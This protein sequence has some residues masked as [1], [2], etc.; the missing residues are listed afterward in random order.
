MGI[1]HQLRSMS[2]MSEE[3]GENDSLLA[4]NHVWTFHKRECSDMGNLSTSSRHARAVSAALPQDTVAGLCR[5]RSPAVSSVYSRPSS[6]NASDAD[7]EEKPPYDFPNVDG[8]F[9]DWPLKPAVPSGDMAT[10]EEEALLMTAAATE[11]SQPPVTPPEEAEHSSPTASVHTVTKGTPFGQ[12]FPLHRRAT[13]LKSK[14]SSSTLTVSSKRSR[15]LER[16]SPPK[17]TVKKRRSIFKFLRPGSRKQQTRSVSSPALRTN[18]FKTSGSYDG[19]SDDPSLL[20]V[21]YELT[22]TPQHG[23]RSTS[24]SHSSPTRRGTVSHLS[25]P[26]ELQRQPSMANYERRLTAA[27]DSRR[28]S[29]SVSVDKLQEVKEDDHRDSTLLRRKLSRAKPLADEDASLMAQALEKHQQEKALFRS[30][31]KQREVLG[32]QHSQQTPLFRT[33]TLTTTGL[34]L[35]PTSTADHNDLLDPLDQHGAGRSHSISYLVPPEASVTASSQRASTAG[36][37]ETSASRRLS[38]ATVPPDIP[39]PPQPVKKIGTSLASWSRFPSHTRDERCGSAGRPDAIITRDFAFDVTVDNPQALEAGEAG[40]PLSKMA[41]KAVGKRLPRSRS[42][43]FS[44]LKRYYSNVFSSSDTSTAQNRRSS[45]AKGG[46]LANPDLELLPP[47][48]S[49]E[50]ILPHHDRSLKERLHEVEHRFEE[51][52]RRDV[53]YVEEE[54]QKFERQVVADVEYVEEEAERFGQHLRKDVKHVGAEAEKLGKALRKDIEYVEEEA[55]KLVHHQPHVHHGRSRAALESNLFREESPFREDAAHPY[56]KREST[57]MDPLDESSDDPATS[58]P[59]GPTE[60][61]LMLDGSTEHPCELKTLAKAKAE[62]F[63]DLYKEC[64]I[65]PE[66]AESERTVD[67][68]SA[69]QA[70]AAAN[71]TMPSPVLRPV[72]TRSP[73]RP[74]RLDPKASVRRFP[75]VTVIDDRKGHSR[76]VS[77]VSVKVDGGSIYRSSTHDLLQ[78]LRDRER[79]ECEKLLT[80]SGSSHPN[81][82]QA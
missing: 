47:A 70:D 53:E 6:L 8:A 40:S 72:K 69:W 52:V 45:I 41:A 77:L 25:V 64:L 33:D 3:S 65:R 16:F 61:N 28:R 4:P 36:S 68:W 62:L 79:E 21:Q 5:V 35:T 44:G 14:P 76:S 11:G 30:A 27:V 17:K 1:H 49:N 39:P 23:G 50:P 12:W 24:F 34:T 19:P 32:S 18:T 56:L 26:N 9:A 7:K 46:W 81:A 63:S 13:S 82:E 10:E 43:V 58:G 59:H 20:T 42:T 71:R 51:T 54:A 2:P 48:S 22:D 60:R 55:E 74:K 75:S 73:E 38:S 15:F 29:S 31:S 78:L 80:P 67:R 57:D 37:Y 66:S